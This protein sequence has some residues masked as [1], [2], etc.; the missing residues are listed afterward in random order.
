MYFDLRNCKNK[1][2]TSA[3]MMVNLQGFAKSR[4][5]KEKT[6]NVEFYLII[7]ACVH[8]KLLSSSYFFTK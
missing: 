3:K 6:M 1:R 5:M 8:L 7:K 4:T 2:S